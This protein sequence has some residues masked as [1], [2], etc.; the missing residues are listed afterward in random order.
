[1][2]YPKYFYLIWIT[3][4]SL[5]II[6]CKS[7]PTLTDRKSEPFEYKDYWSKVDSLEQLR[8]PESALSVVSEIK[9]QARVRGDQIEKIKA[10]IYEG[11]YRSEIED[12][13]LA[14]I[15]NSLESE[16]QDLESP[17]SEILH[18]YLGE[19][20]DFYIRQNSWSLQDRKETLEGNRD[21]AFMTLA[22]LTAL[23]DRHFKSSI[24]HPERLKV[25]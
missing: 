12:L 1:M 25:D 16:I 18:S 20:Y 24:D 3:I 14:E 6:S 15:I 2:N 9:A 8:L 22:E 13:E 10:L 21:L 5:Y 11:K 4:L 19:L 23:A 7:L 17:G